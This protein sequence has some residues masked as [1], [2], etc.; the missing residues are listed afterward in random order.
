MGKFRQTH[1][2]L[3][4]SADLQY[5][6]FGVQKGCSELCRTVDVR[7]T[8]SF[9]TFFLEMQR[10]NA[11][12]KVQK[13]AKLLAVQWVKTLKTWMIMLAPKNEVLLTLKQIK[14]FGFARVGLCDTRSHFNVQ[15]TKDFCWVIG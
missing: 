14:K 4:E 13:I 9:P 8:L 12:Q 1:F 2:L 7:I 10:M 15:S 6:N 11:L 5:D 3:Q